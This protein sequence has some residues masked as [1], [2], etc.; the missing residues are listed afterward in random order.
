MELN[1]GVLDGSEGEGQV[2]KDPVRAIKHTG[3][4]VLRDRLVKD[5]GYT[6]E[7]VDD[8]SRQE[9]IQEVLICEGHATRESA[10]GAIEGVESEGGSRPSS[11]RSSV[12]PSKADDL[13]K[14]LI[15]QQQQF[16]QQQMLQIQR[17]EKKEERER[18]L[19]E[20][21]RREREQ[22]EE[23]ERELREQKEERERELREQE[24]RDREQKEE[25]ERI[26][27]AERREGPCFLCT[28]FEFPVYL[29]CS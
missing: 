13:V 18:E 17:A 12:S 23:R 24:R 3:S 16:Q 9:V 25:R 20:Q 5:H 22:K 27:R 11:P 14:L 7:R 6:R 8:F 4:A 10:E 2:V 29:A 28:T 15:Q 26:K 21:E 19:R 1:L